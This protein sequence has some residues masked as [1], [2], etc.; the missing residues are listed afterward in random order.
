MSRR[1]PKDVRIAKIRL[2][3]GI[4]KALGVGSESHRSFLRG[5]RKTK[6]KLYLANL[7]LDKQ[8]DSALTQLARHMGMLK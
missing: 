7:E 2:W 1:D 4:R 5:A 6:D 8:Q 3:Q